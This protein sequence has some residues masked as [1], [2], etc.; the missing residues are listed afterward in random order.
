MRAEKGF[1]NVLVFGI[2]TSDTKV[3]SSGYQNQMR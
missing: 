2:D 3:L 1:T